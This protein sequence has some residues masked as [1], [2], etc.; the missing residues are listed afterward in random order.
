MKLLLLLL[1]LGAAPFRASIRSLCVRML[2][3]LL[4]LLWAVL[5]LLSHK[6]DAS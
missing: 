1:L 4:P 2:L 5:C 3:L 6:P